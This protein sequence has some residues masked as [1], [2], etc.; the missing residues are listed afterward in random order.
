M[1]IRGQ[2]TA[3][4]DFLMVGLRASSRA[5]GE[6]K[7]AATVLRACLDIVEQ[8]VGQS[9]KV[10]SAEVETTLS[11]LHRAMEEL[12]DQTG[13]PGAVVASI[14]NAIGRLQAARSELAAK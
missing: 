12:D 7:Q 10:T 6:N 13:A 9:D 4:R 2:L 11:V 8:L 14:Q 3:S 1:S 5:S